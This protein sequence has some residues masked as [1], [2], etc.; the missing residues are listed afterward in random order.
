MRVELVDLVST[1]ETAAM[2]EFEHTLVLQISLML[3][4]LNPIFPLVTRA[5]CIDTHLVSKYT[6]RGIHKRFGVKIVSYLR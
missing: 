2:A 5:V 3:C 4:L 6:K 1:E